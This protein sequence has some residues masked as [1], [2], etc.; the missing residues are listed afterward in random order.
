MQNGE[1]TNSVS[2]GRI[3]YQVVIPYQS[4]APAYKSDAFEKGHVIGSR[5]SGNTAFCN[6]TAQY[7]YVNQSIFKVCENRI[8]NALGVGCIKVTVT[9]HYGSDPVVPEK[10]GIVAIGMCGNTYKLDV[11][12]D[13][14]PN[15]MVP[16][17]CL[18]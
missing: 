15:A 1:L 13:N 4:P 2:D 12:F 5:F 14:S 16:T 3:S 6:F 10:F 7:E 18:K 17:A 11:S 9:V 8:A